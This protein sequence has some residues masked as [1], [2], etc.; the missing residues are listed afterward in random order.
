MT[1]EVMWAS[2]EVGSL[3]A[4]VDLENRTQILGLYTQDHV[5]AVTAFFEKRPPV[6]V[7]R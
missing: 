4:A 3:S 2:L 6:F 1:K 5:E 7:D